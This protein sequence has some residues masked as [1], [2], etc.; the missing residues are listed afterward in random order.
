MATSL[1][2]ILSADDSNPLHNQLPS[3]YRSK[4]VDTNF[5]PK[6]GWHSNI[7]QHL[8]TPI[9]NMISTVHPSPLPKRHLDRFSHFCTDDCRMFLYFTMGRPSI[10]KLPLPNRGS[11]AQSNTCSLGPPK[12]STEMA[13]RSVQPFLQ[14]SLVWRTAVG[15]WYSV[16]NNTPHL[17]T[18]TVL[19]CSL[20]IQIML[21][22]QAS[23][24]IPSVSV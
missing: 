2:C 1:R 12:S 5:S 15:R 3:R 7:P 16:G 9:Q 10:S 11:G 13:S 21:D 23:H 18:Y 17:S 20:K 8:W 24:I 22:P 19:W 6:I 14:G 4:S